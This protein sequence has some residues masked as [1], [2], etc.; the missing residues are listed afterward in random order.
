VHA[1]GLVHAP[2]GSLTASIDGAVSDAGL[3]DF[4]AGRAWSRI[5]GGIDGPGEGPINRF[6][7]T[8]GARRR[9][10]RRHRPGRRHAPARVGSRPLRRAL[11]RARGG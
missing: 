10:P 6:A 1:V 3:T 5:G 4:G 8:L 9:R 2:D 11:K 7:G